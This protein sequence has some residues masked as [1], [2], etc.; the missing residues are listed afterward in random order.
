MTIRPAIPDDV[1]QILPLVRKI[2]DLHQ[3]WDAQRFHFRDDVLQSYDRWMRERAKDERSVFF[4]AELDG[5][6][7]AYIIGTIEPEIPIYW[8]SECGWIHDLWVE[9]QYRNEGIARQLVT[10]SVEKFRSLG[11]GQIRLQTASAND[12]GRDLFRTCGFREATIEMLLE[13][14]NPTT[15]QSDAG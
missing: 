8:T 3:Q 12:M 13:T 15:R 9:P 6:I 10:L 11:V 2:C 5:Q 14:N 1:P 4:I 7:V